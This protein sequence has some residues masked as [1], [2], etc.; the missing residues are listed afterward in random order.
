MNTASTAAVSAMLGF[1]IARFMFMSAVSL[2]LPM[3]SLLFS[4]T[5]VIVGCVLVR[6][7]QKHKGSK[8]THQALRM[9][10]RVSVSIATVYPAVTLNGLARGRTYKIKVYAENGVTNIS[11]D[12]PSPYSTITVVTQSIGKVVNVRMVSMGPKRLTIAWDIP[13]SLLGKVTKFH[14]RF[15]PKDFEAG[16]QT[17]TTPDQNFTLTE[18]MLQTDYVFMVSTQLMAT[19]YSNTSRYR[20]E[21]ERSRAKRMSALNVWFVLLS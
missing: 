8:I 9:V 7:F 17:R 12:Y 10:N 13:D 15:Y 5:S 11:E 2:T 21:G 20:E 6:M 14:V 1:R 19:A 4:G 3:V 18:F 16:A